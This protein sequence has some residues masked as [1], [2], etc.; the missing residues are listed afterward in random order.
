MKFIIQCN[1]GDHHDFQDLSSSPQG[2]QYT[3]QKAQEKH[4]S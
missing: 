1:Q 4:I 3:Y 2:S